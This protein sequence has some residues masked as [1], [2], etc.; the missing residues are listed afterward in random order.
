MIKLLEPMNG[1]IAQEAATTKRV[2]ERVPFDKL[3]WKPHPKSWDMAHLAY[4]LA[5][6]PNWA[7]ET[8]KTNS[9][10]YTGYEPPAAPES[11]QEIL[12]QFDQGVAEAR[13]ALASAS[14][15]AYLQN[16]SLSANGKTFFTMPRAAIIR[17]FVMN[18]AIH[19][20]AQLGVY[21]R[22]ND[23]PVPAIYGPSADEGSM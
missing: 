18:H 10:D 5:R 6:L 21:L 2:L 20:R 16:W 14:D 22:L 19:H 11:R 1:E 23:I 4:H 3:T 7:A 8:M 13:A 17:S 9:L 15:E 12:A